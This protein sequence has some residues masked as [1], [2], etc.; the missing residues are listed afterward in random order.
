MRHVA[1]DGWTETALT[2]ATRP[3]HGASV[4]GTLPRSATNRTYTVPLAA[5]ALVPE[6]GSTLTLAVVAGG[7]D[8]L[9]LGSRESSTPPRLQLQFG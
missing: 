4:L 1:S 7:T 6:V 9:L 2:Y 5:T 3:E 8:G